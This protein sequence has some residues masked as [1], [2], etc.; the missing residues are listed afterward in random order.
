[1]SH[2]PLLIIGAGPAGLAVSFAYP[3]QSLLVEQGETVGGLCRSIHFGG[4]VFDIGGHSFHSPHA[5]VSVLVEELMEGRWQTQRRDAR[6]Y[7]DG[8][9]IDYPFQ[10]NVDQIADPAIADD[11]R[12]RPTAGPD[13][14]AETFE[15]WIV[16]RF[17]PGVARHFMLPYNRKL[18]AR[19]LSRMS[20]EW[21]GER[22]AGGE[23]AE[24][25]K[26]LPLRRPLK[27]DSEVG[28]PAEGGFEAIFQAMAK[29]CGPILCGQRIV[30]IDPGEKTAQTEGG[31]LLAW[32]RLV[33]TLPLPELL[34]L[35]GDCPRDLIAD[36]DRLEFVS[37][38][39]VLILVQ[40]RLKDAPQRVYIADPGVPAHK[41]A[42]NHTSSPSLRRRPVHAIMGEVA[43]S[44][45]KPVASDEVLTGTMVEWLAATGLIPS[46]QAVGETRVI[47]VPYGYPVYTHDR[48]AIVARVRAYLE[49]LGIHSLG[50]FGAWD[51]VNS[52]ACIRQG[53]KLAEKLAAMRS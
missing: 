4:G 27:S 19:D 32:D 10:Q 37:L 20:C 24:A 51:Y 50:R 11:C 14:N 13:G 33:S 30:A 29:R 25:G 43:Y 40:D 23:S 5:E 1:M 8:A 26:G 48:P 15:A 39:I 18:W 7:F 41:I 28:Y 42:F 3:G 6:V 44:P 46:T 49:T 2:D 52:D 21:V 35:I 47:D 22:V 16:Q 38:K 34:R 31:A 36:A 12:A 9:L 45:F 17:G 53:L